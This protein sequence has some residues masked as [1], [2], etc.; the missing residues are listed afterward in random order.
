[1]RAQPCDWSLFRFDGVETGLQI[2][3]LT[4]FLDT[5]RFPLRLKTLWPRADDTVKLV[6]SATI[7]NPDPGPASTQIEAIL[8]EGVFKRRGRRFAR[9]GR[10]EEGRPAGSLWIRAVP[11]EPARGRGQFGALGR[12]RVALRT[13]HSGMARAGD[14][15][16]SSR[17]L[18]RAIHRRVHA[19]A[20]I[21]HQPRRHVVDEAADGRTRRERGRPPRIPAAPDAQGCNALRGTDPAPPAQGT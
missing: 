3:G 2:L 5:K 19:D 16:L 1:M 21:H 18:Q 17:S 13:R 20:Q 11:A 15:R 12:V 14:A 8:A 7:L 6:A 10:I 4:R 9:R